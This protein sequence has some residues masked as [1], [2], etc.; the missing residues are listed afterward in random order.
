[1]YNFGGNQLDKFGLGPSPITNKSPNYGNTLA[2]PMA[3]GGYNSGNAESS[4]S[5]QYGFRGNDYR[6]N[7]N[8]EN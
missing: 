3:V 5:G 7:F 2:N 6:T 8:F 4:S 1:M